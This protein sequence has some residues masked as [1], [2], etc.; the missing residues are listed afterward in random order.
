ML[1]LSHTYRFWISFNKLRQGGLQSTLKNFLYRPAVTKAF[2]NTQENFIHPTWHRQF[3]ILL[4][5]VIQI[6]L[7]T[8]TSFLLSCGISFLTCICIWYLPPYLFLRCDLANL[9]IFFMPP[10][11]LNIRSSFLTSISLAFKPL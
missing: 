3:H 9:R 8:E 10:T 6:S 4:G 1:V 5:R 2:I 11:S 7:Y